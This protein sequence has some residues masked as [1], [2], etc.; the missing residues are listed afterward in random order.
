MNVKQLFS[1]NPQ[2][3]V[4][5]YKKVNYDYD[6]FIRELES[7]PNFAIINLMTDVEKKELYI[8]TI[9]ANKN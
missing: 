2:K 4:E 6:K 8:L 5:V 1:V 7:V 3:F 9:S